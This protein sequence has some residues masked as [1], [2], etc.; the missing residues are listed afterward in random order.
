M[1]KNL[2]KFNRSKAFSL[3]ELSF[4][5]VIISV[6]FAGISNGSKII[7]SLRLKSAQNLTQNSPVNTINGLVLWL[8]P[9]LR[10]SF[11]ST[12][13]KDGSQ[14]TQWNDINPQ[15]T[16][17]YYA[18]A[19]ASPGI[20]YKSESEIYS[21][22]TVS[23]SGL[24]SSY[25]TISTSTSAS[26]NSAIVTPYNAFTFFIVAKLDNSYS[27]SAAIFL[28]GDNSSGWGYL[29]SGSSSSGGTRQLNFPGATNN[30]AASVNATSN[31]EII[32]A[33]YQSAAI[34]ENGS[35]GTLKLFTNGAEE[36]LTTS[37]AVSVKTPATSTF[38]IGN[39]SNN[40]AWNGYISELIIFNRALNDSERSLVEKYLAQKYNIKI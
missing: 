32:S 19:S 28:N 4:V 24:S 36:T 34:D 25:F 7:K 13:A 6:I 2:L 10:D 23:F 20:T 9:T 40:E 31:A 1:T 14:L 38:Y 35:S 5:L 22:P 18:V 33:T 39:N 37:S 21:L 27:S 29:V 12:Q 17:K 15:A 11:I 3:L 8:E 30:N 16:A 26:N